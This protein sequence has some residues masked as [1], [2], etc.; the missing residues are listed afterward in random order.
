[1]SSHRRPQ[2]LRRAARLVT[3]VRIIGNNVTARINHHTT[4]SRLP[5]ESGGR[6]GPRGRIGGI[7]VARGGDR[8]FSRFGMNA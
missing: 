4:V 5:D 8:S 3:D 7:D 1:M 2:L 6:V